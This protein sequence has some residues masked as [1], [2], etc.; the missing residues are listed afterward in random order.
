MCM[1]FEAKHQQIKAYAKVSCNRKNICLSMAN[2][3]CYKFC[4]FLMNFES[5]SRSIDS[6]HVSGV[7][8]E[9]RVID[10]IRLETISELSFGKKVVFKGTSYEIGD[11]IVESTFGALITNIV[12]AGQDIIL[13]FNKVNLEIDPVLNWFKIGRTQSIN[14]FEKISVFKYSPVK[15]HLYNGV[16]YIQRIQKF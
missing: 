8:P 7:H 1:R 14:F 9:K 4:D 15:S 13:V 12:K 10:S 6:F 3:I 2:K 16:H 11:Y 5:I